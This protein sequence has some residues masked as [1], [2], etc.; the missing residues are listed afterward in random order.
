MRSHVSSVLTAPQLRRV[1]Q[2]VVPA[3]GTGLVAPGE[4]GYDKLAEGR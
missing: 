2:A 3:Y 1:V 4:M